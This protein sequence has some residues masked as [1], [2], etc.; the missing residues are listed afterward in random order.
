M[1]TLKEI[2]VATSGKIL[3]EGK[4][5]KVKNV[6]TDTRFIRQGCL[7]IAIK[8]DRFDGHD[9]LRQ[10][11][12]AGAESLLVSRQDV[13]FPLGVN[14]IL[15]EDT[16]KAYGYIARL[17]RRR[18]PKLPLIAITGSAGK[19]TTK[20]MVAEVLKTKYRV[21]YNKGTENN[22]IGVPSTL[23][24]IRASHEVAIIETGTNHHGEIDWLA[25]IA[26]P[27]IAV[28][29]NV[30]ASHLEGLGTPEGVFKEKSALADHVALKGALV[31]NADD[32]FFKKLLKRKSPMKIMSYAVDAPAMVKAS[33]VSGSTKGISFKVGRDPFMLRSPVWGNLHN[34]LAAIACGRLLKVK[35]DD[36][37][38]GLKNFKAPQGRQV[39]HRAGSITVIDDTYNANP[40]SFKNAV[41]TLSTMK[42]EGRGIL[43]AADMLE[44][45]EDAEDLHREVGGFAAHYGIDMVMT[46]GVLAKFIIDG[47]QKASV[48]CETSSFATKE[49]VLKAL[50]GTLCPEDIVLVKGSRGMKMEKLVEDLLIFLKG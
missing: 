27:T 18:F 36:M 20:E 5:T 50:K 1:F 42:G 33:S 17:H 7:F 9:F 13:S 32:F 15:V 11:V 43:V 29:T 44:L 4:G 28:F 39:F 24:K 22:H 12:G 2:L 8:G 45:G 25:S 3:Q 23:L 34:A 14:I 48:L 31:V 19:T 40:V 26:E 21:L 46:C 37:R 6:S 10:A 47:V 41:R 49:Q 30:G 16:V 35:N 38:R